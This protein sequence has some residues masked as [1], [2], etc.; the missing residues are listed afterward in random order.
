[1]EPSPD[2]TPYVTMYD[3]EQIENDLEE[4]ELLI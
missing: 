3:L 4:R 1:M 2:N